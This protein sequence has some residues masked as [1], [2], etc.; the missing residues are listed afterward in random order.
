MTHCP[1]PLA[2]HQ[3]GVPRVTVNDI[4]FTDSTLLVN[5]EI[6]RRGR[7]MGLPGLGG[8]TPAAPFWTPTLGGVVAL[9]NAL[10]WQVVQVPNMP[11][12][13]GATSAGNNTG[14]ESSVQLMLNDIGSDPHNGARYCN[15]N[16]LYWDHIVDICNVNFGGSM[17]TFVLGMSW[18]AWWGLQIARNRVVGQ[19]APNSTYWP[20]EYDSGIYLGENGIQGAYV[21]CPVNNFF[22]VTSAANSLFHTGSFGA[23]SV[24]TAFYGGMT[25][26]HTGMNLSQTALN[27]MTRPVRVTWSW[28]DIFV[29]SAPGPVTDAIAMVQNANAATGGTGGGGSTTVASA[30]GGV[31]VTT[32]TGTQ[33]LFVAS[34]SGL[35]TPPN[36][37]AAL[38][39][40]IS[41]GFG[42]CCFQYT[43]IT[44]GATPS[45]NNVLNTDVAV[46]TGHTTTGAAV[47][48][49]V[50]N[51]GLVN[52]QGMSE[53][54]P[55]HTFDS[56]GVVNP[57][58]VNRNLF[59]DT[60][61]CVDWFT[62]L[63]ASYP[64]V[65]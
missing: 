16:L 44:G 11:Q 32:F 9:L 18:G 50:A 22:N 61:D 17:P 15:T 5:G 34:T 39:T 37:S 51:G 21:H 20:A 53:A 29:V 12:R 43:G 28:S 64:P 60:T 25:E 27:G 7:I 35:L 55:G 19:F 26:P 31:D 49:T 14:A 54:A 48:A 38:W 41:G 10:G 45:L 36:V 1:R 3:I 13:T 65:Y 47:N 58:A 56:V 33:S 4:V 42:F 30:S 6:R 62:G 23:T 59:V 8:S 57:G 46:L 63:G 24:S 40:P 52:G 2:T